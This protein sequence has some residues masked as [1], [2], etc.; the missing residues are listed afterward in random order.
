MA[1]MLKGVNVSNPGAIITLIIVTLLAVEFVK[2]GF[3][4]IINGLTGL[5]TLENFTFAGFFASGGIMGLVI[6]AAM[7][8]GLLAIVGIKMSGGSNR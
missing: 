2:T 6:S 3:P 5:A 4:L 7:L 1:D 8:I